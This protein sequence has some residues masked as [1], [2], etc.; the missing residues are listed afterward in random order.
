MTNKEPLCWV[1]YY[2]IEV[3]TDG[4]LRP[5]CKI[6]DTGPYTPESTIDDFYSETTNEWRKKHFEDS[7]EL[8][9]SCMACKVPDNTF[10]YKSLNRSIWKEKFDWQTP[11]DA[12]LRKIV[13]ALDNVCAS[14]CVMCGPVYSSTIANFLN[15]NTIEFFEKHPNH[16]HNNFIKKPVHQSNA[17][18]F[19]ENHKSTLEVLHI[20]GGEP[21]ISPNLEKVVNIILDTPKLK[22]VGFSTGL[23]NIKESNVFLLG[24]H[25]EKLKI[26]ANISIDGPLDLN[27]WSRGI[28]PDEFMKNFNLVKDNMTIIGLQSTV[29]IYNVFALPELVELIKQ[30]WKDMRVLNPILMSAPIQSPRELAPN[31]LPDDIKLRVIDKLTKYLD[32]GNCPN[33][34]IELIKTGINLCKRPS[35]LPWEDC[36]EYVHILPRLRGNNTTIEEWIEKY[37]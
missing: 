16:K 23:H 20:Y 8:P 1:P 5:C 33:Y 3:E 14:S 7:D 9:E 19:L 29:G 35:N 28:P 27:H 26:R 34:A 21:L 15:K 13:I 17:L 12:S 25:K 24:K 31:Q 37:L 4:E 2:A 11:T 32:S 10:S 30:L 22:L 6:T 36:R 18:D